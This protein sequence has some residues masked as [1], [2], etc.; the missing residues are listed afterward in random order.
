M[1]VTLPLMYGTTTRDI[2]NKQDRISRL[3]RD[4]ASGVRLHN[5]HDDPAAWAQSL[6]LQQTLQ[7]MER[8]QNNLNFAA[9]ML[10][11][12]DSGLNHMHDLLVRATEIGMA[13]NTPN[14]AEEKEAFVE[15]LDQILQELAETVS[16]TANGQSVFAGKPVWNETGGQWE[17]EAARPDED[18]LQV[19][20]DD[21][22]QTM[23]VS[24]DLS[25]LIPKAMNTI[26]ALKTH[27]DHEDAAGMR[28][29]LQDLSDAMEQLRGFSSTVGTRLTSIQRRQDT[30]A[31]LTAHRQEH[32]SELRDT[33]LLDAISSLQ[34]HQIA[35]EAALKSS[36]VLKDLSLVRY[37]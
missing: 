3:G 32:L 16:A 11:V 19:A 6:D 4:I 31:I 22:G 20:L 8:Y 34:T 10:S 2:L 33:D 37:L 29:A 35:L 24:T 14:S 25:E 23:T 17:W 18:P 28:A 27:I 26:E 9:N 7:R 36:L 1:R 15:E 5:P 12:A 13:A 21:A 30:L